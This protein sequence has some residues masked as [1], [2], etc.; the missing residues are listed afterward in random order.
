VRTPAQL[1]ACCALVIPGG[2][3]TAMGLIAER[4]GMLEPLRAWSAARKPC[5]GTCAGMIMLAD[6]AEGQKA[7]GQSLLGGLDITVSRNFFGAQCASFEAPLQLRAGAD[8]PAAA[9]LLAGAGL[10]RSDG[11]FIR[12]PAILSWGEGVEPLAFVPPRGGASGAPVCVA[13]A[14]PAFLVT[15]FHPELTASAAW[16]RLFALMAERATGKK[17]LPSG[18][19]GGGGGGGGGGVMPLEF[20]GDTASSGNVGSLLV[21]RRVCGV[22][23]FAR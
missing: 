12:A 14:T 9:A 19:G 2:E 8:S 15:A 23:T 4:L 5:W 3:S 16:H 21:A 1:A 18:A 6:R 17:L 22:G 10:A 13:A 7:G 20:D 11:V